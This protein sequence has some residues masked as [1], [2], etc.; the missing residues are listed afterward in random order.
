L[1]N[2]RLVSSSRTQRRAESARG[3]A[4][5][6]ARR[7][8]PGDGRWRT[9]RRRGRTAR[10]PRGPADSRPPRRRGE[11]AAA[12]VPARPAEENGQSVSGRDDRPPNPPHT[13]P[14]TH[15]PHPPPPPPPQPPR[16]HT[17]GA[18]ARAR[19]GVLVGA[20]DRSGCPA[21][22]ARRPV[23]I[24]ITVGEDEAC[25]R[26]GH[27]GGGPVR[28][29]GLRRTRRVAFTSNRDRRRQAVQGPRGSTGIAVVT[30]EGCESDM[31]GRARPTVIANVQPHVCFV[32]HSLPLRCEKKKGGLLGLLAAST[33][34]RA[35]R[36]Y[37]RGVHPEE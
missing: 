8:S 22:A 13:P 23:K 30:N 36:S 34:A 21:A 37:G 16:P 10:R 20:P 31:K 3:P 14:Q 12:A 26:S 32:S 28:S 4:A 15:K 33:S 17:A 11:D 27:R 6:L 2:G 7:S 9:A 29:Q 19:A 24:P 25:G 18:P 1:P 35:P 5:R